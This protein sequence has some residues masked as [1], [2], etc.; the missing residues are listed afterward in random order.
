MASPRSPLAAL[1]RGPAHLPFSPRAEESFPSFQELQASALAH[2]GSLWDPA[3]AKPMR[4]PTP[5]AV[6]FGVSPARAAQHPQLQVES[7]D[8]V[9]AEAPEEDDATMAAA[10]DD[11]DDE[12]LVPGTS[13]S[14]PVQRRPTPVPH[15]SIAGGVD[16][17]FPADNQLRSGVGP[18]SHNA[19][20]SA[21]RIL[22]PIEEMDEEC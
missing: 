7:E 14:T 13:E 9:F 21:H 2:A 15:W 8:V 1:A 18:L 17:V 10:D 20:R 22:F 19:A 3:L 12:Q 11:H 6:M 5:P 4:T 16:A